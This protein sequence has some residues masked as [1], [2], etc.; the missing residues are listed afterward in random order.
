MLCEWDFQDLEHLFDLLLI[1]SIRMLRMLDIYMMWILEK[2]MTFFVRF[3]SRFIKIGHF[4][5]ELA[6][7]QRS[8]LV[9]PFDLY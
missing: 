6:E 2:E 1:C 9:Q 4:I 5:I 3:I 8:H 7:P